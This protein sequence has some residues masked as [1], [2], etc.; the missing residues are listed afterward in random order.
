MKRRNFLMMLL[1]P[2]IAPLIYNKENTLQE[3]VNECKCGRY[4]ILPYIDEPENTFLSVNDDMATVYKWSEEVI[5]RR[6][7]GKWEIIKY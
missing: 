7:N 1:A 4:K 2:L 6:N 3:N 5:L